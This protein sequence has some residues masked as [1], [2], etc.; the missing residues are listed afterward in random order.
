MFWITFKKVDQLIFEL[1]K[2]NN[3]LY[4]LSSN[5][6]NLCFVASSLSNLMKVIEKSEMISTWVLAIQMYGPTASSNW[7]EAYRKPNIQC[8]MQS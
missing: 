7:N 5:S 2:K 6:R 1:C 4:N 3:I 8:S